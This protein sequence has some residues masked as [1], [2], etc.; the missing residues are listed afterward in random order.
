MTMNDIT[1]SV[2]TVTFNAKD[3]IQRTLDSVLMQTYAGVEHI[4]MDGASSDGTADI[5]RRYRDAHP[6]RRIV[7]VSEPDKGLYDAMNKAMDIASGTYLCF[8]NAGDKL[9]SASS[10]EEVVGAAAGD[11][12]HGLAGVVY[13]NTDIVDAEGVRLRARRLAPPEKLTSRSF[14][15]GMLVC[16]Q[17]FYV[18]KEICLPYDLNYRF[19]ADFDW[20]IRVME[21]DD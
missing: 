18:N 1:V 20:C 21:K 3:C 15:N 19:S 12:R 2:I 4:I 9:H 16:H 7:V 8:L 10:L 5:A 13:G 11:G 6:D 17:A 14:C